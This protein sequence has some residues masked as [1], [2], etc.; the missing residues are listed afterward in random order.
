LKYGSDKHKE[1]AS[2]VKYLF[3]NG[4]IVDGVGVYPGQEK[5]ISIQ[6]IDKQYAK[7]KELIS[8]VPDDIKVIITPGN[9][10][11]VRIAEPQPAFDKNF[12]YPL[13]DLPDNFILSSNP[14]LI[15]IHSS[16][17]FEGYNVLMYHGYS[18]DYYVGNVSKFRKHGYINSALLLR[19]LLRKRHLAP[20]HGSTLIAPR[21]VDDLMLDG[22]PDILTAAHV[23]APSHTRY[24]HVWNVV[25][26]CWQ[27]KTEFQERVGHN[28]VP[29][30]AYL[31]S[32][33]NNSF[34]I[35]DFR[36]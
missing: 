28:P 6:S 5:D 16:S 26:S 25:T 35:M 9:H 12:S 32:L 36:L 22:V 19:S 3:I 7:F 10:D 21:F 23:H 20:T 8:K 18:F 11:S 1:L 33:K 15:N 34:R 29:G 4:D 24:K 14:S 27:A 31:F 17:S 30:V 13:Y 2:K